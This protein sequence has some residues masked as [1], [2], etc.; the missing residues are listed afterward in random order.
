VPRLIG[1]TRYGGL[2]VFCALA[3]HGR[4]VDLAGVVGGLA[5]FS[6]GV[7]VIDPNTTDPEAR[8]LVG[9][10]ASPGAKGGLYPPCRVGI[11]N[12]PEVNAFATGPV[13]R[14]LLVA[15]SAGS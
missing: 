9:N 8:G 11:Y 3:R 15:V 14:A 7:Q 1:S 4:F 6:V 10:G 5:K 2:L 13:N 12:S